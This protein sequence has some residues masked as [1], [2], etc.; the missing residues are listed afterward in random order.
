MHAIY[1]KLSL[2]YE[3]GCEKVERRMIS[4][5]EYSAN[6]GWCKPR[7]YLGNTEEIIPF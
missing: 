6:T 5:E 1:I 3:R 2:N 4:N 7:I